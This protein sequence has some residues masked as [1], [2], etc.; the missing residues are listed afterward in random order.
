VHNHLPSAVTLSPSIDAAFDDLYLSL[1]NAS[2]RLL[3][4]KAIWRVN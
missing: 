2:G 1:K 3:P 4:D